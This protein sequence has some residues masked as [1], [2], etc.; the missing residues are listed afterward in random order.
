MNSHGIL[1]AQ[2]A[3]AA[4]QIMSGEETPFSEG[5]AGPRLTKGRFVLSYTGDLEGGG[6]LEELKVYFTGARADISGL[7]RFTG[8]LG[9]LS[10]SFVLKHTGRLADG[11]IH[12][13]MTV[14]PGSATGA[15]KGLRGEIS[16]KSGPAQEFPITFYYHFA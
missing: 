3:K 2:E 8:R 14:V 4:F 11:M 15:L 7:Q 16:L 1:T 5:D 10:G 9:G 12:S 13:K 6:I